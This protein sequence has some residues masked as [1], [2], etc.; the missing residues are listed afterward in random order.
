MTRTSKY[1][2]VVRLDLDNVCYKAPWPF[3]AS[4]PIPRGPTAFQMLSPMRHQS[5]YPSRIFQQKVEFIVECMMRSSVS[6]QSSLVAF[7]HT[8]A[9]PSSAHQ[10][11]ANA[12]TK[13]HFLPDNWGPSH[14][15]AR[16]KGDP[17][18]FLDMHTNF[19]FP[20]SANVLILRFLQVKCKP[21]F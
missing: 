8:K 15:N 16:E 2:W 1:G 18:T 21:G 12:R 19:V 7:R 11:V 9:S 5:S 14:S 4:Y 3:W 20:L 6:C 10:V 13:P 17:P